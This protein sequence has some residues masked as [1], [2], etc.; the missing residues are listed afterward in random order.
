MSMN[1]SADQYRKIREL[2]Y[3][4]MG[5]AFDDG[6]RYFLEKRLETRMSAL[7]IERFDDYL[8]L[9]RFPTRGE[10][11]LQQ[12]VNEI[13]TNETY[14]FREFEQLQTFADDCLP[15][16]LMRKDSANDRNLRIWCA[17]CSSGEEAYTLAMI[18]RETVHD[19][20]SWTLELLASDIDE[21]RLGM[22]SRAVYDRRS[23]AQ[24]PEAYYDRY[25]EERDG[26]YHIAPSLKRMVRFENINL[27]DRKAMRGQRGFDFV[28]C[29]NVLIYFD[30]VSRRGV[31]DNFY[32]AMNSGGFIFLGHSESVGR[33]STKF[34]L[35]RLGRSLVYYK[36]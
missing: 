26:K 22:A 7:R 14:M 9:L 35:K 18:L 25:I 19:L 34:A 23:V 29:R 4:H 33:F 36:N 28:F 12:F 16:T 21:T 6:K 13:T 27:H 3:R 17:G 32:N 1:L 11:E 31:V 30:E 10:D 15:E 8:F 24:V 20:D 5:V 2:I